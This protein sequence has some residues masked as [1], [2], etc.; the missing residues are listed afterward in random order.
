MSRRWRIIVLGNPQLWA[1][2]ELTCSSIEPRVALKLNRAGKVEHQR[3]VDGQCCALQRQ[4]FVQ[5]A[6]RA[7]ELQLALG[8]GDYGEYEFHGPQA[9]SS[10]PISDALQRADSLNLEFTALETLRITN[11]P[12]LPHRRLS[13]RSPPRTPLLGKHTSCFDLLRVQSL[14]K[15]VFS[16][17]ST[18]QNHL[19]QRVFSGSSARLTPNLLED[20]ARGSR[21]QPPRPGRSEQR[22]TAPSQ[23]VAYLLPTGRA[24]IGNLAQVPPNTDP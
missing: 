10:A 21:I 13:Q 7:R 17:A 6:V 24:S 2:P 18:L 22:E 23:M 5:Y 14:G 4:I 9:G 8:G 16:A 3:T 19:L 15:H 20:R 12:Q 11:T 1:R